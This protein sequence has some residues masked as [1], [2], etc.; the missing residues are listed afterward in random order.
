MAQSTILSFDIIT[1]IIYIIQTISQTMPCVCFWLK[2]LQD[3]SM[4]LFC[5]SL[6]VPPTNTVRKQAVSHQAATMAATSKDL[7]TKLGFLLGNTGVLAVNAV[8]A[9]DLG[10]T[11]SAKAGGS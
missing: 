9:S 10:D 1:K 5:Y 4:F 11:V 2:C 8:I 3:C 6:T 7:G